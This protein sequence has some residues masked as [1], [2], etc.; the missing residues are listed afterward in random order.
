M[1][2]FELDIGSGKVESTVK[3]NSTLGQ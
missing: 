1:G 3:F 2:Q